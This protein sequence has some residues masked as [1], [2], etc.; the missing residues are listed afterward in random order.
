MSVGP[1]V[2]Q[3]PLRYLTDMTLVDEDTNSIQTEAGEKNTPFS[4]CSRIFLVFRFVSLKLGKGISNL[5]FSSQNCRDNFKFHFIFSIGLLKE[6]I[7]YFKYMCTSV[8]ELLL[9]SLSQISSGRH[10][11]PSF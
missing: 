10:L 8:V 4:F 11:L 9:R 5:S 3:R 7:L 6:Q 2:T 1:S